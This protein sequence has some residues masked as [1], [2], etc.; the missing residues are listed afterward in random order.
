[1]S[2]RGGSQR[3]EALLREHQILQYLLSPRS[4][5]FVFCVFFLIKELAVNE[6]VEANA[7]QNIVRKHIQTEQA[8]ITGVTFENY[9]P[10]AFCSSWTDCDLNQ[11]SP[12]E[13]SNKVLQGRNLISQKQIL[14]NSE[15]EHLTQVSSRDIV[16]GSTSR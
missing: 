11:N 4:V 2:E 8:R 10:S 5:F 13:V 14:R 7:V 16:Q 9:K 15:L 1:M 6:M 12:S 3:E